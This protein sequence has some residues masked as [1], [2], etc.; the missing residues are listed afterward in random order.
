MIKSIK[1]RVL[2]LATDM[3]TIVIGIIGGYLVKCM[4]L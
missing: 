2:I 1:L 4:L 3:L